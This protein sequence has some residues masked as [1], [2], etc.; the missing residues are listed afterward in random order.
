LPKVEFSLELAKEWIQS[1]D[2]IRRRC[3]WGLLYELSKNKRNKEL[4]DEFLFDCIER[5]AT[6]IADEE[7]L[8]RVSMGSCLMGI[9]KRTKGL[10]KVAL[11]VAKAIGPIEYEGGGAGCEPF[12][13]AKHL[14]SPALQ[15]KL[16]G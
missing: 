7:D 4:T 8:V 11:K 16:K 15:E 3:G 5:I 13:V 6:E 12:D 1:E 14:S 9:G 2:E 10:N